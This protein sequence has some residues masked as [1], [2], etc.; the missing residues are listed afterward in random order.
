MTLWIENISRFDCKMG[1]HLDP[2]QR[3]TVLIQIIDHDEVFPIPA[4]QAD[5]VSIH[6]F[7]FDDVE[8]RFDINCITDYQAKRLAN[9]LKEAFE[10]ER[11]VV[12]HCH[13]GICRSGAVVEVGTHLGFEVV[14]GRNR[15]P[16]Y[17]VKKKML[18]A[19]G[20]SIGPDNSAFAEVASD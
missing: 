16:N 10:D 15:L 1:H 12:V 2:L 5:F 11:N 13:A 17:L 6:Q 3:E 7:V 8:D 9:I 14:P 18:D 19:L 20:L 4:R